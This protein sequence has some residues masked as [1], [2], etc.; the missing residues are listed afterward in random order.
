MRTATL[1]LAVVRARA[2]QT[3]GSSVAADVVVDLAPLAPP[4]DPYVK[5]WNNEE[6]YFTTEPND[7]SLA[8]FAQ[9]GRIAMEVPIRVELSGIYV[10][11]MDFRPGGTEGGGPFG[12]GAS[13]ECQTSVLPAGPLTDSFWLCLQDPRNEPTN[14][15]PSSDVDG[16]Q[17]GIFNTPPQVGGLE[18]TLTAGSCG[19]VDSGCS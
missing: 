14:V 18:L 16:A 3:S 6:V 4:D 8:N 1:L 12:P 15:A 5:V 10:V 17:C 7:G 11:T 2:L 9:S 19:P 13:N